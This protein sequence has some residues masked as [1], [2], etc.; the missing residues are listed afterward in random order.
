MLAALVV[1]VVVIVA[2]AVAVRVLRSRQDPVDSFR[3]QIDALSPEA[4]RPTVD[5]VRRAD[6]ES[7]ES[8]GDGP[9]RPDSGA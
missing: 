9:R 7:G 1:A 8:G 3:R 4:R 5:K 2:I 6:E